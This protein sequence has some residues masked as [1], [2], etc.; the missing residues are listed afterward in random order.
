M[1]KLRKPVSIL[2]AAF[3]GLGVFACAACAEE[4]YS[5]EI[6]RTLENVPAG[7]VNRFILTVSTEKDGVMDDQ[8]IQLI[9]TALRD[10]DAE[11]VELLEGT[12]I[13][14]VNCDRAAI[15]RAAETGLLASVQ[16]D[17]LS[18]PQ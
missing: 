3:F 14:F 2:I 11:N 13:I 6:A 4:N 5:E 16:V 7:T 8:N 17:R 1:R 15:Y 9:L 10:A 18:K 12:P